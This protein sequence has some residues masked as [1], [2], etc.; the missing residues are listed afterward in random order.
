MLIFAF[1]TVEVI[2]KIQIMRKIMTTLFFS[3]FAFSLFAPGNKTLVIFAGEEII[4]FDPILYAFQKVESNFD[5]DVVNSLGYTGILQEGQEMINEA[6]RI[7]KMTGN[8]ARFTF[9]GSALDSLQSVQIWYIVQDYWNPRYE[10]KRACKIWN[11]LA[12]NRYY[13]KI[14]SAL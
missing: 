4:V 10:V 1:Q 5:T 8:P 3:L 12:S 13:L 7:C 14:K 11:P 2:T 6:N 9:P